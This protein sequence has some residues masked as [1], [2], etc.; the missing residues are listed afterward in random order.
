MGSRTARELLSVVSGGLLCRPLQ[1][2]RD[3]ISIS[4]STTIM[5]AFP[6]AHQQPK[7]FT[8]VSR[9]RCFGRARSNNAPVMLLSCDEIY[10]FIFFITLCSHYYD[11]FF[12]C[13][14]FVL[15][16]FLSVFCQRITIVGVRRSNQRLLQRRRARQAHPTRKTRPR[17]WRTPSVPPAPAAPPETTALR[18]YSRTNRSTFNQ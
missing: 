14:F 10:S 15:F 2:Y 17:R 12:V 8:G 16:F 6:P 7:T 4:T 1:R 18:R 9:R 3:T 11:K 5:I 13:L